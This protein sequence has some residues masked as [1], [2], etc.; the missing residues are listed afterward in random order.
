MSR[1]PPETGLEL[2]PLLTHRPSVDH[3]QPATPDLVH[4]NAAV[5][6]ESRR[7]S[8]DRETEH[9]PDQAVNLRSE[10]C[11]GN[12]ASGAIKEQH[13]DMND[14]DDGV[15]TIIEAQIQP[16]AHEIEQVPEA[17]PDD[18]SFE[19][20]FPKTV[21]QGGW[22][23]SNI[24]DQQ[25]DVN[26]TDD[27]VAA[28]V[29]PEVQSHNQGHL[30]A[31]NTA[32]GD[33][34]TESRLPGTESQF[35]HRRKAEQ[36][37]TAEPTWQPTWL[38]RQVF[39]GFFGLFS[40]ITVA[41]STLLAFSECNNGV[42]EIRQTFAYVWRFGPTIMLTIIAALW[43]RVELQ[44]MRYMPAIAISGD[45]E[46]HEHIYSLNYP[47]L[48]YAKAIFEAIRQKHHLVYLT[49]FI[50][51]LLKVQI[52]LAPGLF[53]LIDYQVESKTAVDLL[54]LFNTTGDFG[55]GYSRTG[56]GDMSPWYITRA[57]RD[58]S[59]LYPF[60]VSSTVAYQT[61]RM[62]NPGSSDGRGTTETPL[63]IIVNGLFLEAHCQKL[64]NLS[65]VRME[66]PT[67][68]YLSL[69]YE[70]DLLFEGCDAAFPVTFYQERYMINNSYLWHFDQEDS[71]A[72]CPS[73]SNDSGFIYFAGIFD[74]ANSND[75]SVE[76]SHAAAILCSP[77][78]WI[79][80][81]EVSDDGI[82][83][84]INVLPNAT[85]SPVAADMWILMI[86]SFYG[87]ESLGSPTSDGILGPLKIDRYNGKMVD[88]LDTS[89]YD[90]DVLLN[91]TADLFRTM[92]ALIGHYTLRMRSQTSLRTMGV[93]LR[94]RRRLNMSRRVGAGMIA[95]FSII[96]LLS[97]IIFL[98]QGRVARLAVWHRDPATIFG[99]L[100]FGTRV[101]VMAFL[102]G[103]V[104]CVITTQALSDSSHGLTSLN[105]AEGSNTHL[106][107]TSIPALVLLS[108][109]LYT[110][111]C[112]TALRALY[113]YEWFEVSTN[114]SLRLVDG[115]LE[116][117]PTNPP[118]PD[119]ATL[120]PWKPSFGIPDPFYYLKEDPS[121]ILGSVFPLAAFTDP[122]DYL[123]DEVAL[124]M[125]PYGPFAM[126]DLGDAGKEEDV[127]A[128]LIRNFGFAAAQLANVENR[129]V[130]NESSGTENSPELPLVNATINYNPQLRLVQNAGPAYAI[131]SILSAVLLVNL[132]HLFSAGVRRFGG[133]RKRLFLD[134]DVRGIAPED[135]GSF[136]AMA[137]LLHDSN[138]Y[139]H[140]PSNIESLS[141]EEL[142]G[143][144]LHLRFRMGWFQNKEG[145]ETGRHFTIGVLNDPNTPFLGSKRDMVQSDDEGEGTMP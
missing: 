22:A 130:T 143:M 118:T 75:S 114:I 44:A 124:L 72:R 100:K 67:E 134:M 16:D 20:A 38:R 68:E 74:T 88:P 82:N 29:S 50:S 5:E 108:V 9:G 10:S 145:S 63:K 111:S 96:I 25:G 104:G 30:Q 52:A 140:L 4:T 15:V 1:N 92:G 76:F 78:A 61:F 62:S 97:V 27:R 129:I 7:R 85:K 24:N 77:V 103:L 139:E 49:S 57:M 71:S 119:Y 113:A 142:H 89:T 123:L 133:T 93:L 53:N 59:M 132:W 33:G 138:V 127:L 41:I 39:A 126:E 31:H 70:F 94:A 64:E 99:S 42:S 79:Q 101:L 110:S 13:N 95:I 54:D 80:E 87:A 106:L 141:D 8:Y 109:S 2:Q 47:S 56:R 28:S 58:F 102:L 26:I 23:S 40:M 37:A 131:V 122:G 105:V 107:W 73:L 3:P 43:G 11:Q 135:S 32:C 55:D 128:G 84:S 91:S 117:D 14:S 35:R 136:A 60:G 115:E 121:Y 83:P 144:L 69:R 98:E 46:L 120:K 51:L 48:M 6:T 86:S 90:S 12:R 36:T 65:F 66:D 17:A 21:S 81:V 137:G 45:E 112:A 19:T 116:V 125:Q 34:I 18:D